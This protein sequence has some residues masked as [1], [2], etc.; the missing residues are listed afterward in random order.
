MLPFLLGFSGKK[1]QPSWLPGCEFNKLG[2]SAAAECI[3][4][5]VSSNM[6]K[7]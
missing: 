1:K 7:L 4:V 5:T 3:K 6:G 2:G